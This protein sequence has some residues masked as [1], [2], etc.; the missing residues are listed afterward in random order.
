MADEGV[1]TRNFAY[2]QCIETYQNIARILGDAE[3]YT[4]LGKERCLEFYYRE[5]NP[6]WVYL[7][8]APVSALKELRERLNELEDEVEKAVKEASK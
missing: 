4:L 5:R 8:G 1:L 6:L 2:Q 7:R 3:V